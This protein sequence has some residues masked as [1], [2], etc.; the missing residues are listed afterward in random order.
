LP[1][2]TAATAIDAPGTVFLSYAHLD[3]PKVERIVHAL[4][5]EGHRIW[6]DR[7]LLS[8]QFFPS[9]IEDQLIKAES[10]VVAWS[11]T[12]RRSV[13]VQ[14][15]ALAA[16]DE[17][18]LFQITLDRTRPPIPFNAIHAIDF[19]RWEG[20]RFDGDPASLLSHA[21]KLGPREMLVHRAK[22]SAGEG[23]SLSSPIALSSSSRAATLLAFLCPAVAALSLAGVR[24]GIIGPESFSILA[25]LSFV[26]AG[27]ATFLSVRQWTRIDAREQ[28]P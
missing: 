24:Y 3:R 7:R 1:D 4:E 19:V 8:G 27:T 14:G 10:V 20:G 5:T 15:E 2:Q 6:W 16:L 13:W 17:G 25:L 28:L 21:L 26:L 12:S 23:S 18:K 11:A 22:S 9:I